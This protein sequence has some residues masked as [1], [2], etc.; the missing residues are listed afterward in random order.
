M[1]NALFDNL[2]GYEK[3]VVARALLKSIIKQCKVGSF[4]EPDGRETIILR[5]KNWQLRL[6]DLY[7]DGAKSVR[8]RVIEDLCGLK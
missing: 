8:E 2:D 6:L 5:P 7:A 3:G 4:P 1:A